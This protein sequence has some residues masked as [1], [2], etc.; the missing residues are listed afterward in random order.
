[1]P[2]AASGRKTYFLPSSSPPFHSLPSTLLLSPPSL[3]SFLFLSIPDLSFSQEIPGITATMSAYVLGMSNAQNNNTGL[4]SRQ[5]FEFSVLQVHAINARVLSP[6]PTN[7]L[8]HMKFDIGHIM[9]FV[10]H[11]PA[12][13]VSAASFRSFRSCSSGQVDLKKIKRFAWLVCEN[14]ESLACKSS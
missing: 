11:L 12:V 7:D 6:A 9:N 14:I 10:T 2:M 5:P 1:M 13:R 4:G 3:P 8:E